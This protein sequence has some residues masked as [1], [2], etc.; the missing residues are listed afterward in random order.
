MSRVGRGGTIVIPAP[1][2]RRLGMDDGAQII[3]EERDGGVLI[4]PAAGIEHD[5]QRRSTLFEETDHAYAA[6][7]A[8]P[9]AW[10]AELAERSVLESAVA[11]GLDPEEVWTDDD[12]IP[13]DSVV[14]DA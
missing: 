9:E 14:A 12:R 1:V 2:R 7:R 6:L 3:V 13:P 8:D 10:A 4:R 5:A 11:D